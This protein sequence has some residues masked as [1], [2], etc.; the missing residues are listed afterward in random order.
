[1]RINN[2][3]PFA[4][5]YSIVAR[6]PENG[7]MGVAVQS[8]W[9]SVGSLVAWGKAGV[10]VVATQSMV[11]VS[12]GPLGL[13]LM[14]AGKSASS[15]LPALTRMD[16]GEALRQVAMVDANGDVAVH[17]GKRCINAAG[18]HVGKGYSVQA[19]MMD[20]DKVWPAMAEAYEKSSGEFPERLL[21]ALNAAQSVGGDVR[22]KQSAAILVVSSERKQNEWEGI[23]MDLRVE[24][25]PEPIHE[26]GRLI[27]LHKAY[28]SM[29]QGD[30]H[31][32]SGD[33]K[34][35]LAAYQTAAVLAPEIEELPFWQAVTLAEIGE[36]E[37]AFPIFKEIFQ[38]DLQWKKLLKRLPDA[39]L[40]TVNDDIFSKIIDL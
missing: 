10:G 30:A 20:N 38:K 39:G 28:D 11:E 15:V 9:F 32:G 12:Y 17:T 13:S 16:E 24:D 21:A 23:E 31:L 25:H 36:L 5:T 27:R 37:E 19:N 14:E 7:K 34:A 29:N 22:G 2:R 6:D 35:A 33:T 1:M 8:H 26:L 4:H 40:F 18:H 3:F